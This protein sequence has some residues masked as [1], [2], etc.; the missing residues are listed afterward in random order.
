MMSQRKLVICFF[1]RSCVST[2]DHSKHIVMRRHCR[3]GL[4]VICNVRV[5]LRELLVRG[6]LAQCR[7]VKVS[8]DNL[9]RGSLCK[10]QLTHKSPTDNVAYRGSLYKVLESYCKAYNLIVDFMLS[11]CTD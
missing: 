11:F 8:E 7:R 3:F 6:V 4:T 5:I 10:A 2:R 1:D 9:D